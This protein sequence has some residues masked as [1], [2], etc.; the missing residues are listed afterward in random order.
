MCLDKVLQDRQESQERQDHQAYLDQ[1]EHLES[2][3]SWACLVTRD[4]RD[5]KDQGESLDQKEPKVPMELACQDLKVF[6]ARR[7]SKDHQER[8]RLEL[9]DHKGRQ[10]LEDI[11][12]SAARMALLGLWVP[13]SNVLR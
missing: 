13:A 7:A 1:L 2:E 11:L 6:L 4:L 10:D 8:A 3:V 5:C 9:M 12:A